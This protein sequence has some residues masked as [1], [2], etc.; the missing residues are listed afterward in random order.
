MA[1]ETMNINE[2][3]VAL[4]NIRAAR[5]ALFAARNEKCACSGTALQY[6][7]GCQCD[8]VRKIAACEH[9]IWRLIE[10]L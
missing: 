8:R 3:L 10:S 2:R 7:G 5:D 9:A 4:H 1:I 6:E